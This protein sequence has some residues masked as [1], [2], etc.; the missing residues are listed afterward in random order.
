MRSACTRPNYQ[1]RMW[2]NISIVTPSRIQ[3]QAS[4]TSFLGQLLEDVFQQSDNENKNTRYLDSKITVLGQ[5]R[6]QGSDRGT[7]LVC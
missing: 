2:Q 1:S 7:L 3:K 6:N 5:E 4:H